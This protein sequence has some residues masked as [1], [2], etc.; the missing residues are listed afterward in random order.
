M[1]ENCDELMYRE[2]LLK[3]LGDIRGLFKMPDDND[4]LDPYWLD[5]MSD[6]LSVK[7]YV[8][9]QLAA[10]EAERDAMRKDAERYRW[11]LQQSWIQSA[12]DRFDFIDGG[13][14]KEFE[15]C[16]DQMIDAAIDQLT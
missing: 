12:F 15:R 9:A 5:A 14:Q 3:E 2:A 10:L 7:A 13:M 1:D 16:A 6:P 8:E 4:P 11:L